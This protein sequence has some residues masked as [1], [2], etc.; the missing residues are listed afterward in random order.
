MEEG[1][2]HGGS[3]DD[4]G[5]CGGVPGSAGTNSSVRILEPRRRNLWDPPPKGKIMPLKLGALCI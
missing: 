5:V 1:G 3:N 2:D 4:S